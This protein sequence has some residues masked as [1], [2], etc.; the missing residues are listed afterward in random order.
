MYFFCRKEKG[1]KKT[2]KSIKKFKGAAKS[3]FH[4]FFLPKSSV[5]AFFPFQKLLCSFPCSLLFPAASFSHHAK[6][7]WSH[8]ALPS[9]GSHTIN[10]V[11]RRIFPASMRIAAQL[12]GISMCWCQ[13][14]CCCQSLVLSE[15]QNKRNLSELGKKNLLDLASYIKLHNGMRQQTQKML[16]FCYIFKALSSGKRNFFLH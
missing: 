3:D 10:W 5:P 15:N 2:I 12:Q 13:S 7:P 8:L 16:W 1:I 11:K 14:A 9:A 6:M 4:S